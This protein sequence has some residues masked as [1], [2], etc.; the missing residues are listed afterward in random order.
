MCVPLPSLARGIV[1]G[2]RA[3]KEPIYRI[4]VGDSECIGR[5][6]EFAYVVYG[7]AWRQA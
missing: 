7:W 1:Q 5:W 6:Y 4:R 2:H 3:I